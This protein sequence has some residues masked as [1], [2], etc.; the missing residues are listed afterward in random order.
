MVHAT[1]PY[2]GCDRSWSWGFR[3]RDQPRLSPVRLPGLDASPAMSRLSFPERYSAAAAPGREGSEIPYIPTVTGESFG[4][5]ARERNC[6]FRG[7][8][9]PTAATLAAPGRSY[10]A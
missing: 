8:S 7:D 2:P 4:A 10:C 9:A 5:H 1:A 3:W 6:G